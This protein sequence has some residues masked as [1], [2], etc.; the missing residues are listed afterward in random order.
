MKK[1]VFFAM[2]AMIS[3]T[4][5]DALTTHGSISHSHG[6]DYYCNDCNVKLSERSRQVWTNTTQ[7]CKNCGG[8]GKVDDVDENGHILKNALTCPICDGGCYEKKLT[9]EYYLHCDK[10]GK[11]YSY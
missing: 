1:F 3:A 8:D 2:L 9:T 11:D 4:I 5:A 7:L 10:C 6:D